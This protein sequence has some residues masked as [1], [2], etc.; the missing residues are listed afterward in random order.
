MLSS[1]PQR[2]TPVRRGS[3]NVDNV[4]HTDSPLPI[5]TM[6]DPQPK[7]PLTFT[8]CLSIPVHGAVPIERPETSARPTRAD[9]SLAHNSESKRAPRKSKTEALV[10][11]HNHAHS[12]DSPEDKNDAADDDE[13]L[14]DRIKLWSGPPIR[15]PVSLDMSSVKTPNPRSSPSKPLER[16]FGLSD[17]PTFR[18]TPEQ[19]KDPMAYIKSIS[20]NART[21]GMCKIVPPLGWDMPFVTDTEVRSLATRTFGAIIKLAHFIPHTPTG[22]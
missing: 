15:V 4:P 3:L 2:R 10:A 20:E 7:Q 21:Y 5:Q 13:D 16:P 17:C 12:S 1:S 6:A 14:G 22:I 11:L 18:P 19:F 8:T 9:S